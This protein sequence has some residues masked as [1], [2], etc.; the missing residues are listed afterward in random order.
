MESSYESFVKNT[1]P[2]PQ[3]GLSL[4]EGQLCFQ[5]IPL[6]DVVRRYG[7]PLKL[8]YLPLIAD[9]IQAA[10][11]FFNEAMFKEGY[12]GT[13]NYCYCLK[14]NFFVPV[15]QEVLKQGV[16][17]ETS[18][19]F[20]VDLVFEL[21]SRGLLSSD[22]PIIHNGYKT[23]A[24]LRKLIRLQEL[25]VV[26][27]YLI[28]DSPEEL[29]RF[30]SLSPVGRQ[31]SVRLGLRMATYEAS[32]SPYY[33]SRLGFKPE[34]ILPFFE[35]ELAGKQHLRLEMLH[36]FVDSGIRDELHYWNEFNKA[37]NLYIALK[38]KCPSL[39]ALNIGGGFPIKHRLDFSYDF[40]QMTGKIVRAITAAC[41]SASVSEPDIYTEFGSYTVGESGVAVFEVL[42]H[43]CQAKGE[44]WYI[45]NNSL[46]NTL[47]DTWLMDEAFIVLPLNH[48]DRPPVRVYL[49]GLS[50]DQADYYRGGANGRGVFL[51]S[52][53]VGQS[54]PLYLAFLHTAAYQDALGGYGG[55]QHC[56]I[57][58]VQ[59][60]FVERGKRGAWEEVWVCPE[61]SMEQILPLLGGNLLN[62]RKR[63]I[64]P[65]TR[66]R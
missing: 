41:R 16:G 17:L 6:M 11:S 51:P 5:G 2:F 7:S 10:Q 37:L 45:L 56:L 3:A 64:S 21:L 28:L 62:T 60:I 48:W 13:Y 34:D 55:L 4:S 59:Q 38:K 50:C 61:Q 26:K 66:D 33:S 19:A 31:K 15:L 49:G 63:D 53:P 24:Y 36:F 14:S 9:K 29:H 43:K 27:S 39:R 35:K 20:D 46:L 65:Q 30:E 58:S 44:D 12:A 54:E 22:K 8:T 42:E 40:R 57:P 18:S 47:P 1:Y 23:D 52:W 32:G 25:G